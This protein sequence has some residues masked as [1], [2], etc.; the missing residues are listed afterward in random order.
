MNEKS[1]MEEQNHAK[2]LIE[3]INQRGGTVFFSEL[4]ALKIQSWDT[5]LDAMKDA[6]KLENATALVKLLSMTAN[7]QLSK[8]VGFG[9]CH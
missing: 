2:K 9:E 7:D 5:P 8:F 4:K 6:L 3:L 1:A